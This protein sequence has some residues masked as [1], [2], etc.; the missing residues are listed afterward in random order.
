MENTNRGLKMSISIDDIIADGGP[1]TSRQRNVN[2]FG[3]VTSNRQSI[4][5]V[6]IP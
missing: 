1:R 5:N 3:S 4:G 6:G 2:M